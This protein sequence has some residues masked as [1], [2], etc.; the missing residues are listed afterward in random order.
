M[1]KAQLQK[2]ARLARLKLSE[3]EQAVFA[4]EL[5]QVFSYFNR[6]ASIDTQGVEPLVYPLQGLEKG[7]DPHRPDK[8]V[9]GPKKEQLL[10]LAPDRLGNEYKTPPVF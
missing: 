1:D 5:K 4:G 6:I 2:T 8:I 3:Q 7:L 10:D 9:P